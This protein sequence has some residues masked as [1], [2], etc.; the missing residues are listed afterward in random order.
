MKGIQFRRVAYSDG[1]FNEHLSSFSFK[2]K[3]DVWESDNSDVCLSW[4]KG[5]P[6]KR[7][8]NI[9]ITKVFLVSGLHALQIVKRKTRKL[10]TKDRKPKLAWGINDVPS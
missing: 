9:G 8:V 7:S 10:R 2:Y 6:E 1:N 5:N 4:V 3:R